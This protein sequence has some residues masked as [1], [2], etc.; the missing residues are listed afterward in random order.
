MTAAGH[1]LAES[2]HGTAHL[3]RDRAVTGYVIE[4]RVESPRGEQRNV[5]TGL[6]GYLSLAL[7]GVLVLDGITL[8]Q[9][10]DGTRYIAYPSRTD[11]G[12]SR[13]AYIKPLGEG[14]RRTIQ[15]Q[16]FEALGVRP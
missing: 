10:A 11:H 16:V 7:N 5:E 15:D 13:H 1:R 3:S 14:A 2:I 8:R 9:S 12:G 6:L 4:D